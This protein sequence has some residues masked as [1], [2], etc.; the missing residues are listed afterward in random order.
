MYLNIIK[1]K[2]PNIYYMKI[3]AQGIELI[4]QFESLKLQSY[5]DIVG[6]WTC[7]YGSTGKDIGAN[8]TWTEQDAENRL[9]KD[10]EIFENGINQAVK[11]ELTTNQFSALV[12]FAYNVGLTAFKKS[13]LLK[14]INLKDFEGAAEE[15]LRWNKAG[16]NIVKGLTRRRQAE[17][18]LFKT[19]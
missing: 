7:G 17:Q 14:K 16:G 2:L 18:L 3:N 8:L 5:Q 15:F 11:T 10:L 13:T 1:L 19:L 6:V 12:V 9:F 4:K